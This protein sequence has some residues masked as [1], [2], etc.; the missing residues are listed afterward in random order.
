MMLGKLFQRIFGAVAER[1]NVV[2]ALF[3]GAG[4]LIGSVFT[5]FFTRKADSKKYQKEIAKLQKVIANNNAEIE[6]LEKNS[7][8]A[9][10]LAKQNKKLVKRIAEL[11]KRMQDDQAG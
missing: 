6:E 10:K 9:K 11:E 3:T 2:K 5:F 4:A 7:R 8:A 1:P